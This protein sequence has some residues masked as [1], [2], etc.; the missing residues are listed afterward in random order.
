MKRIVYLHLSIFDTSADSCL[1]DHQRFKVPQAF[2]NVM[3]LS[4][5]QIQSTSIMQKGRGQEGARAKPVMMYVNEY[6]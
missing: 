1:V 5:K 4:T 2:L 6:I 3:I